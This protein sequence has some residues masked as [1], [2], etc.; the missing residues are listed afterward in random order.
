VAYVLTGHALAGT[1]ELPVTARSYRVVAEVD[2]G[3]ARSVGLHL[4]VGGD[5]RTTV[6]VQQDPR[7]V[8]LDR[9]RSGAVEVHPAF[10]A[11][12]TAPLPDDG[13]PVRLEVVVDVASVEVFAA[14]G[15]VVLTD[16]VFPSASSTG[17][18]VFAEDGEAHVRRLT[19]LV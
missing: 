13:G 9:S 12:H 3:T 17:I 4:R 16:Q 7:T 10:A 2:P 19:V 14:G 11:A 18:A 1:V 6:R 8:T 5:E 15:E